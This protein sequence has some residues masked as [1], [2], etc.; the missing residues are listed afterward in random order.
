MKFN[1]KRFNV[2]IF[3]FKFPVDYKKSHKHNFDYVWK[4]SARSLV[5]TVKQKDK[6][7]V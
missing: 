1:I 3:F 4:F 2:T 7:S 6:D 5:Y